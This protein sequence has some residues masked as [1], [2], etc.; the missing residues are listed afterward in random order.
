MGLPI[1][2]FCWSSSQGRPDLGISDIR[3]FIQSDFLINRAFSA[4]LIAINFCADLSS[5]QPV[6]FACLSGGSEGTTLKLRDI[7]TAASM[8]A[9]PAIDFPR[10]VATSLSPI[11]HISSSEMPVVRKTDV[12][13]FFGFGIKAAYFT[14]LLDDLYQF[15]CKINLE[16]IS[17]KSIGPKVSLLLWRI[18]PFQIL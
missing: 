15:L 8:S 13:P 2:P 16:S 9:L 5:G 18:Q 11:N 14:V 3:F 12:S 1:D 7:T 4:S 10:L 6:I 17:D